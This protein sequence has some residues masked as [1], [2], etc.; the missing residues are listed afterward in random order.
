M[1]AT[2][3]RVSGLVDATQ[4]VAGRA[5]ACA[6]LTGGS[7][8]GWGDN[9]ARAVGAIEPRTAPA[10]VAVPGVTAAQVSASCEATCAR[11]ADGAVWCWGARYRAPGEPAGRPVAVA[12]P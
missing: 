4:V 9:R 2:P 10:P 1:V 11:R 6:V 12:L 8:A 3:A 5:H 7:V